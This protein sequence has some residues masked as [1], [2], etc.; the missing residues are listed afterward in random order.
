MHKKS[1]KET[2][3]ISYSP[4]GIAADRAPRWLSQGNL[5]RFVLL[6]AAFVEHKLKLTTSKVSDD[7]TPAAA[8]A[9]ATAAAVTTTVAART[10]TP[11]PFLRLLSP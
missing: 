4:V 10:L 3:K 9:A 2:Q 6:R 7:G 8:A 5:F 1:E 11:L